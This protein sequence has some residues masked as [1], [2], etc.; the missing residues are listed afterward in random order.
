MTWQ[1]CTYRV[2]TV[3][4]GRT[5]TTFTANWYQTIAQTLASRPA[6]TIAQHAALWGNAGYTLN[7][8]KTA[9][10]RTS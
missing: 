2:A 7:D 8:Y 1:G 4:I 5:T 9:P 6:R 10:M 3:T